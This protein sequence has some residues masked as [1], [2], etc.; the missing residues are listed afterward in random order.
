MKAW[1]PAK[2]L[3]VDMLR[4]VE[5]ARAGTY[6]AL[7]TL[8]AA[9]GRERHRAASMAKAFASEALPRIGAD[10]IQIFGG[11]GF[12]WEYDIHLYYKRLLSLRHSWGDAEVHV[13]ELARLVIDA[14]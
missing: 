10:A 1:P 13:E 5:L 4:D 6:Y 11:V 2:H 12:T 3:L 8:D 14:A 9:P 7:W